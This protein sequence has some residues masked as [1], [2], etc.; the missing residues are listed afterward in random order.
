MKLRRTNNYIGTVTLNKS[1]KQMIENIKN[2]LYG[3]K[4]R[5]RFMGRG[6]RVKAM[7]DGILSARSYLPIAYAE[8]AD[9]YVQSR[10]ESYFSRGQW[11]F[12]KLIP[13]GSYTKKVKEIRGMATGNS[14]KF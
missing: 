7:K 3:S 14:L 8:R 2:F 5:V 11:N 13:Q 4:F 6:S 12:P 9:L 10:Q 1:G